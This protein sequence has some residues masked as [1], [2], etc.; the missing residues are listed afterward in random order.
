VGEL[1]RAVRDHH[2]GAFGAGDA[3]YFFLSYARSPRY[4]GGRQGGG[5]TVD[6]DVWA[7]T[8]FSDLCRRVGAMTALPPGTT[9]GFMACGQWPA[10]D[11]RTG[12]AEAL[13]TCRVFVPLYSRRYFQSEHCGKEWSA[14]AGRPRTQGRKDGA[15][16]AGRP[17]AIVPAL[18]GAVE[19]QELPPAARAVDVDHAA[20]GEVYAQRGFYGIMKLSRY[21]AEYE[22]AVRG[23]ARRIVEAAE[24]PPAEPEP[25]V[26]Y[27]VLP[28]AFGAE[29]GGAPASPRL[30]ITIVAPRRGELPEHRSAYHYGTAARDWD[31][32]R[33]WS[34]QPLA[35]YAVDLVRGLGYRPDVGDLDEHGAELLGGGPPSGPQ[36]LIV[37]AWATR[38]DGRRDL[39]RRLDAM[40]KPWV[41]VLIPWNRLDEENA[42]QEARLRDALETSL[43]RKLAEGRVTSSL[44]VRGVPTL[45]DFAAVLPAVIMSAIRHYFRYAPTCAAPA[46]SPERP[47]LCA[48]TAELAA[49]HPAG[50]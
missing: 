38:Q 49:P 33:P 43:R 28:N 37:D 14:F 40:N 31:P 19:P 35:D 42:A 8:L 46:P 32:Y 9:A 29:A 36:V 50:A 24:R 2:S 7:A 21:R 13:G 10:R 30:R 44:A 27:D 20:L 5:S 18:W 6:P 22:R 1:E 11:W 12:L 3:P 48:A 4:D 15:G 39:L 41:Q 45:E 25:A 23:L 47:R 17:P 34:S 16:A 26:D